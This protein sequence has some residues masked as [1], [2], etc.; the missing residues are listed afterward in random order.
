[1]TDEHD[2]DVPVAALQEDVEQREEALGQVLHMLG[3]GSRGVHQAE[4]HGLGDR[5]RDL[6][7]AAVA[8]V[9]RVDEADAPGPLPEMGEFGLQ[10]GE[11]V[12]IEAVCGQGVDFLLEAAHVV[13]LGPAQRDAAR[14]RVSHGACERHVGGRPGGGVAGAAERCG[15]GAGQPLLGEVRQFEIVEEQ[16]EIFLAR[17][18]ET[19][20]VLA[21]SVLGPL[22]AGA[23]TTLRIARD[24]VALDELPV[25]REQPFAC[26]AG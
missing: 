12:R 9:D 19:E 10:H 20:I 24:G 3:H 25:A 13:A 2:V 8:D 17:Q 16:V 4:H 6:L 15:I 14:Q 7:E 26:S 1:V 18:H 21:R 23:A 22:P 5:L 11:A